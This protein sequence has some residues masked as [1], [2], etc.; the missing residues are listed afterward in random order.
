MAAIE[1]MRI[2]VIPM[3]NED[4]DKFFAKQF[5]TVNKYLARQEESTNET[6]TVV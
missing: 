1:F 6:T 2:H 5:P 3:S 4:F